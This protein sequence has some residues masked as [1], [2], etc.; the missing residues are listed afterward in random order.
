M[1][2]II[3]SHRTG[4][5]QAQHKPPLGLTLGANSNSSFLYLLFRFGVGLGLGS[6]G[7]LLGDAHA[8]TRTASFSFASVFAQ[9]R[10][11]RFGQRRRKSGYKISSIAHMYATHWLGSFHPQPPRPSVAPRSSLPIPPTIGS[12]GRYDGMAGGPKCEA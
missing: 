10:L 2:Y 6:R 7:R 5:A 12:L 1:N 11:V 3:T 4:T 9:A 8:P